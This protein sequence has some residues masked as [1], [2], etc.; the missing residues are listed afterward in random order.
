MRVTPDLTLKEEHTLRMFAIA[1]RTF[2]CEREEEDMYTIRT[3]IIPNI[4]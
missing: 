2:R 1:V 4:V 3:S